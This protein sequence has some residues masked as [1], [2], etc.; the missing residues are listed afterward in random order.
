LTAK[1]FAQANAVLKSVR[2][3]LRKLA[4]GDNGLLF[5]YR[6]KVYKEL[7][8]D[9]R[10]KPM[11]RRRMKAAKRQEQNGKCKRCKKPLP[12]KYCVLDRIVAAAGYTPK[13]TR[14]LCQDCDLTIQAK[15]K[16]KDV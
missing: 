16:W 6:R 3:R 9:E 2:A 13:N 8:Y 1:E 5:A 11:A 10:G 7:I 12:A 14:L 15:R 4:G